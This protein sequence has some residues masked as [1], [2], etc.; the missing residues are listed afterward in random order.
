MRTLLIGGGHAAYFVANTLRE[1]DVYGKLV[2]VEFTREK[3]EMLSKTFPFAEVLVQGIDE[4]EKYI[5]SNSV[6]LDAVI[7]ATE[8]DALNLRYSKTA[9]SSSIPLVIAVLNN[10]LNSE[11][12]SKEGIRY[13]VNPYA[14]IPT[15]IKEMLDL[16]STNTIYEFTSKDLMICAVKISKEKDLKKISKLLTKGEVAHLYTTVDGAI[17]TDLNKLEVGG[18]L[19]VMGRKEKVKKILKKLEGVGRR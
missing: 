3:V 14:L 15:K 13:I 7:A 1:I 18:T 10:P 9:I 19:Y 2:I 5:G 16:F 12:F 6:L 4:V 17:E 8:S 11:I